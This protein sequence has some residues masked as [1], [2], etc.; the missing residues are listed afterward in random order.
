MRER[1]FKAKA[2]WGIGIFGLAVLFCAMAKADDWPGFQGPNGDC[3]SDE[4]GLM[5]KWP[6]EGPRILW[7]TEVGAGFGGVAVENGKVYIL[8]RETSKKDILRCIDL[9]TGQDI[10]TSSYDAP[11]RI[12]YPGSRSHP[13]LDEE[14]IYIAG[15]MGDLHCVSKTTHQP[16]WHINMLDKFDA[17]VPNWAISQAPA[18]YKDTVIVAPIGSLA[19]VVALERKTGQTVWKSQPLHG[20][21]SYASPIIT[22]IDAVDQVLIITTEG[23]TGVDA[24]N[25]KILWYN[26]DWQCRIPIASATPLGDGLVFTSGGYGSGSIMIRVSKTAG[27]FDARTLFKN[28]DCKGQIHQPILH[29]GHLYINANDKGKREG[30]MCMD[31]KGNTKWKTGRSPGFDWGGMLMA[32]GMLY[33]VDGD[34]GDLC[35]VKPDPSG[36]KEVARAKY[37]D[38]E[39]MWGTIA[40]SDGRILLRDQKKLRCVDVKEP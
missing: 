35:M 5:K 29:E 3:T 34:A 24:G 9:Q 20:R 6:K 21:A 28:G 15:P 19:G 7:T 32:D 23:V 37:L 27:G 38:G 26:G 39:Q 36:Y 13:T 10:W 12:S 31:L 33:V 18:L 14:N 8:D 25:G 11:G 1:L 2:C 4:T 40:I 16:V 30:L 22:T 17:Q